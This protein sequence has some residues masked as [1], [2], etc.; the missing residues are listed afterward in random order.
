MNALKGKC[1][2]VG[3]SVLFALGLI[4]SCYEDDE[5]LPWAPED[6]QHVEPEFG[7]LDGRVTINSENGRVPVTI[8]QGYFEDNVVVAWDVITTEHFEF[9]LAVD[10]RYAATALYCS[11]Q[12]TIMVLDGCRI[13]ASNVEY[14]DDYCWEVNDG[15]VDLR[16]DFK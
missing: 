12:D 1:L 4:V 14:R 2:L 3:I 9:E 11:G 6:C 13:V 15:E 10:E 8:Y 5:E 7:F 16:L